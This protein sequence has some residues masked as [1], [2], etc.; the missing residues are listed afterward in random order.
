MIRVL[1]R[2]VADWYYY[3][4][5]YNGTPVQQVIVH[6]F[7]GMTLILDYEDFMMISDDEAW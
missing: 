3:I 6:L 5:Y 4:W 1:D 2:V 7:N